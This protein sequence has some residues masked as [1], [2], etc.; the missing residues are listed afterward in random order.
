DVKDIKVDPKNPI[1]YYAEMK[2]ADSRTANYV[3]VNTAGTEIPESVQE[4]TP[5]E[6]KAI[7]EIEVGITDGG[8]GSYTGKP[9]L[10]VSATSDTPEMEDMD[11][12]EVRVY[13]YNAEGGD[14][15][16]KSID[17][18]YYL[19]VWGDESDPD[20][21]N[22]TEVGKYVIAV[23]FKV[24]EDYENDFALSSSIS[25]FEIKQ[26]DL[27]DLLSDVKW[28][29]IDYERDPETG[30]I[31]LDDKG[32]P[33][34]TEKEYTGAIPYEV[35]VDEKGNPVIDPG[36]GKPKAK[37]IQLILTGI[38][39]TKEK[40]DKLIKEG[41]VPEGTKFEDVLDIFEKLGIT[42]GDGIPQITYTAPESG[43]SN[44]HSTTFTMPDGIDTKNFVDIKS[45]LPPGLEDTKVWA[46]AP[47]EQTAPKDGDVKYDG[48]NKSLLELM[49]LDPFDEG[50]YYEVESVTKKDPLTGDYD[51]VP[52]GFD[53]N[54]VDG[55][56]DYQVK[57]KIIDPTNVK[58]SSGGTT[59]ITRDVSVL[60]QKL[61][62]A[63]WSI[64]PGLLDEPNVTDADGEA[65]PN[66]RAY[67]DVEFYDLD[68]KL[69]SGKDSWDFDWTEEKYEGQQL[70]MVLVL[71]NGD[72]VEL[73]EG[74]EDKHVFNVPAAKEPDP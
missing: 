41:K 48:K 21:Y 71:K 32:V 9:Q 61:T 46:I 51:P 14:D 68:N 19:G 16:T 43:V 44:G 35:E 3:L 69:V 58:W 67:F 26:R 4:F 72:Y 62:I 24:S 15:L 73:T 34:M 20:Y 23:V 55:T 8:D 27:S 38:P 47:K 7:V 5:G 42:D 64:V 37:G 53:Y 12:Y 56:G 31:I 11:K 2:I 63:D 22:P 45:M 6:G 13:K 74:S 17:D 33:K 52:A 50:K 54:D 28:G 57:V 49:G 1:T 60:K 59:A 65:V 30:K 70:T 29:Y 39:N 36:T 18:E 66:Y 10:T 25:L 40:L